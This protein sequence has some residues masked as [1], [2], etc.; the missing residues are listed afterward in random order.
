MTDAPR[1]NTTRLSAREL[2]RHALHDALEWQLSLRDSITDRDAPERERA[3][4]L[5]Q[6]YRVMLR[7][8]YGSALTTFEAMRE[9]TTPVTI[10]EISRRNAKS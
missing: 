8:R 10:Q 3:A 7:R 9:G 6:Q 4:A 1:P 2:I 5:A